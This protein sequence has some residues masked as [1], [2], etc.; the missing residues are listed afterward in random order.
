MVKFIILLMQ[1]VVLLNN[2]EKSVTEAVE[3]DK[4]VAKTVTDN[5]VTEAITGNSFTE[6][7]TEMT[8]LLRL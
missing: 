6:A 1:I 5:D 7:L 4:G 3:G 8:V 2:R